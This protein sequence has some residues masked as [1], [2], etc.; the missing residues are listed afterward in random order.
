MAGHSGSIQYDNNSKLF[1]MILLMHS[2]MN[3]QCQVLGHAVQ[4]QTLHDTFN[5]YKTMVSHV[6]Q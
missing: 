3:K 6:L 2:N 4:L 1:E 5:Y